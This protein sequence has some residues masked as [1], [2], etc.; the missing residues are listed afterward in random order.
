MSNAG[1]YINRQGNLVTVK[2]D[3]E[4]K[5]LSVEVKG[6]FTSNRSAQAQMRAANRSAGL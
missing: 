2:R 5:V 4:G 3:D 1:H 6:V